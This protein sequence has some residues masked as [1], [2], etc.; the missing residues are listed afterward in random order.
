VIVGDIDALGDERAAG[1]IAFARPKS[2]GAI[3]IDVRN[4]LRQIVAFDQ[5]HDQR[6]EVRCLL[7]DFH[8][9]VAADLDIRGFE[10][11]TDDPL[12]VGGLRDL[13]R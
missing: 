11:A 5:L 7:Q 9:A 10:I 13:F 8:C 12:L 1:S 4:P 6:G 2:N 3:P